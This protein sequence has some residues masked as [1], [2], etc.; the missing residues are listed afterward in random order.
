MNICEYQS[1]NLRRR[2]DYGNL[3]EDLY[4]WLQKVK[5]GNSSEIP[6]LQS[7]PEQMG[8]GNFNKT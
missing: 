8:T 6:E 5:Y 7:K 4:F 1:H 3:R 2:M